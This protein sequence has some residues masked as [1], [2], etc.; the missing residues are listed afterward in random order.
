MHLLPF[1]YVSAS[2]MH[3]SKLLYGHKRLSSLGGQE[4][5]NLS[6]K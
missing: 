5:I 3:V 1:S 4:T 6:G 2:K